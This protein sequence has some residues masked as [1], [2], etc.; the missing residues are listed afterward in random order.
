VTRSS[1]RTYRTAAFAALAGVTTRALRHY[2]RLGLLRPKRSSSGY[3]LYS[4]RDLEALE[5]IVALKF[6]GVPLKRI[7]A[8]RRRSTGGGF[9]D[10]LRAQRAALEGKRSTLTRAIEAIG[11][12]E[13]SVNSGAAVDAALFRHIIEVMQMDANHED[14]L[15][16]YSAML[17]AKM[18]HLMAMSPGQRAELRHSWVTLGADIRDALAAGERPEGLAAQGLLDRWIRLF[19]AATGAD[20]AT[21]AEASAGT[22]QA[23]PEVRDTLWARRADWMPVDRRADTTE[24][25]SADQARARTDQWVQSLGTPEIVDFIK[26]ARAA[27]T[28]V[29]KDGGS[30]A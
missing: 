13:A 2:D 22:F 24:L 6:I 25:A 18:T 17:K 16:K 20:P 12:A 1:E 30:G 11:R 5:E 8:M 21:A 3:R 9:A 10:V 29:A 14:L 26:R 27:R 23:T 15:L 19:Q 28:S 4:E 7:P